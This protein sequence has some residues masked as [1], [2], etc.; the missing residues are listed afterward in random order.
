MRATYSPS[1]GRAAPR[2]RTLAVICV[3]ALGAVA[4]DS[5]YELEAEVTIAPEVV[6]AV[7]SELPAEVILVTEPGRAVW[8][9]DLCSGEDGFR[10]LYAESG[11]CGKETQV[12]VYLVPKGN[13]EASCGGRDAE[14]GSYELRDGVTAAGAALEPRASQTVFAGRTGDSDSG[15]AE[16]ETRISLA[17]R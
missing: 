17:V 15:C 5:V 10:A 11:V 3:F 7:A 16:G 14:V 13:G 8:L 4:C 1:T 12:N 2:G 9:G 6:T